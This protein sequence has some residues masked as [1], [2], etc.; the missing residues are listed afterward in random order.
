[1]TFTIPIYCEEGRAEN[2]SAPLFLA[3]PLFFRSPQAKGEKL[4]RV[5]ARLV[6]DLRKHLQALGRQAR[7]DDLAPWTFAPEVETHLLDLAFELRSGRAKGKF[8][9]V[10]LSALD[11]RLAFTPS[12]PE[13]WF[14][15]PKGQP[16][17][18]R[19]T[20]VLTQHFREEERKQD[21]AV[22]PD[23]LGVPI[24]AWVSTLDLDI[25]LARMPEKPPDPLLAF[26]GGPRVASG[27][28]ELDR[29][30]RC[31]DWLY[32]DELD[33][34]VLRERELDELSR[35]LRA[36]DKRPV[37]LVGPRKVGKTA[38]IHEYV[39]RTVAERRSRH[40]G[41]GQVWLLSPQRLISGMSFVG[42]WEERLLAILREAN[43]RG[44]ILYFDDLLGLFL[45]GVSAQSNLNVAHVLKSRLE[46]REVRVLGEITPEAW[47]VLRERDRGMADLFHVLPVR[48]TTGS[49]TLRVVVGVHRQIE[50]ECECW[51]GVDA[52]PAV[53]DVQRRF[54]KDQAFPGKAAGFLRQLG[55]KYR[56]QEIGR[57]R[58][59]EEF[60]ASSGVTTAFVDGQMGYERTTVLRK[61]S[62]M[63]IGQEAA[64]Q[65][66]ADV[67]CI[68]RA[69]L[70]DPNR[71]LASF[72]FVGPTGVGKTQCA[73]ATANLLFENPERL[74]R[75]D[76][77]E[78]LTPDSVARLIGTFEQPEGLLTSA[79][80]RRPFSV[81]LLDEI[82]KAHPD[83]FD[84]LLQVLGEGR[85]T[86]ALGRTADFTNAIIILTSNLG[87]RE[88]RSPLGF[89]EDDASQ[90]REFVS[91]AERFFRPEFF[92]RLDRV[93]PFEPLSREQVARIANHLLRDVMQRHGLRERKCL[94]RLVPP[95][96]ERLVAQGYHPQLGARALK[97]V[98]ER[99]L[100]QP[101]A[102]RLA[103]SGPGEPAV[104]SVF[105]QGDGLGVSTQTLEM[106]KRRQPPKL[107][108]TMDARGVLDRAQSSLRQ[109]ENQIAPLEPKG[110]V[111]LEEIGPAQRRYFA[112]REQIRRTEAMCRRVAGQVQRAG[113]PS[114]AD[115]SRSRLQRTRALLK[116]VASSEGQGRFRDELSIHD[117]DEVFTRASQEGASYGEDS[118]DALRDVLHELALLRAMTEAGEDGSTDRVL[119]VVEIIGSDDLDFFLELAQFNLRE[120]WRS[121]FRKMWG[122]DCEDIT[123]RW[124]EKVAKQDPRLTV[125]GALLVEG[126]NARAVASIEAGT[127]LLTY[128]EELILF[129]CWVRPVPPEADPFSELT[130]EA[131]RQADTLT[132]ASLGPVIRLY[133]ANKNRA[134]DLRT[135]MT[136]AEPGLPADALR[137]LILSQLPLPKDLEE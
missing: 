110:P 118:Q 33:R 8:L 116:Q 29:V 127:H 96:M 89:R 98:I 130:A 60:C 112:I 4:N 51:F 10:I 65:A 7:H 136:I 106:A 47:R 17:S 120:A 46:R 14:E 124:R 117:L 52:L 11:R 23:Q 100:A 82:E 71:P 35:L 81:L 59:I 16:L 128:L 3:R 74:V 27:A 101:V 32:P 5:T 133:D 97:R 121:A 58:V 41:R 66:I 54:V 99:Q 79:I 50:N 15:A 109:I 135:G 73:K 48:E 63:V 19:A 80:R 37:L 111:R 69:R 56:G 119:L 103:A 12:L 1:M 91:A 113:K 83:V 72:L 129:R 105:A 84:L 88:A 30:G 38:L 18:E 115:H 21:E 85:L 107:L 78:F 68:A 93:V 43:K 49:E 92:N 77:N 126:P 125:Y 137:T 94:L 9:F 131:R 20:E 57:S 44:H 132:D 102:E 22:R 61:L 42:Q 67:I 26:L 90:A 28:E 39:Y 53:I 36:R 114:L 104:I 134:L 76:M 108:E 62:E 123:Q 64:L 86:D 25:A 87:T 2:S 75:F 95:V 24:R 31:L 45:A 40:A 34:V 122:F 6:T 55:K 13:T 70:A